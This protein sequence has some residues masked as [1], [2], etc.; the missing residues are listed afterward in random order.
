MV[1]I[2]LILLLV[3]L[4]SKI[5]TANG[6]LLYKYNYSLSTV[7]LEGDNEKTEKKENKVA[8]EEKLYLHYIIKPAAPKIEGN[9]Y[10]PPTDYR[11][12]S[13]ISTAPKTPPPNAAFWT[14]M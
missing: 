11:P 8:E 10:L 5:V 7:D 9:G 6:S 1:R 14:Q 13:N 12:Y 4:G 2:L 3:V